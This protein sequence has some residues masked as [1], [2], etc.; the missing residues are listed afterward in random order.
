MIHETDELY[1]QCLHCVKQGISTK[2]YNLMESRADEFA[3]RIVYLVS[4]NKD[5]GRVPQDKISNPVTGIP[6]SYIH[7]IIFHVLKY[8][9]RVEQL[10]AGNVE[11]WDAFMALIERRVNTNLRRVAD[12]FGHRFDDLVDEL[13]QH[14]ATVLWIS[15]DRY[16]YDTNLE[17]W[18]AQFVAFEVSTIRRGSDFKWNSTARS[19]DQPTGPGEG[20]STLGELLPDKKAANYYEE[21]DL[22]LTVLDASKHLT[23]V[24]REVVRRILLLGQKPQDIAD[25]MGKKRNTIYQ[26]RHRAVTNLRRHIE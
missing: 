5:K 26:I 9:P 25:E 2:K 20:G 19:L 18:V 21:I 7:E 13:V 22:Y 1:E 12:Q 24:Q 3:Q 15:F 17:S 11:S 16:P 23:P 14:C 8:G 4:A 10:K 6:S